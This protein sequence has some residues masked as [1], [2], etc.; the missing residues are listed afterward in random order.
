MSTPSIT[1]EQVNEFTIVVNDNIQRGLADGTMS[2]DEVNF[3]N[4]ILMYIQA[5]PEH[6]NFLS[7]FIQGFK[8]SC[9]SSTVGTSATNA[10]AS[11][12]TDASSTTSASSTT[13]L[14]TDSYAFPISSTD[15]MCESDDTHEIPNWRE[16]HKDH[17]TYE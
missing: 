6:L 7:G 9:A 17:P 2:N 15:E 4:G 5:D 1:D 10:S 13:G 11:S 12:T 16:I 8:A 3:L 14:S